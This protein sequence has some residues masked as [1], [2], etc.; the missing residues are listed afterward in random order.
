MYSYM[1]FRT[2]IT[3]TSEMRFKS[4]VSLERG[5][6]DEQ[7]EQDNNIIIQHVFF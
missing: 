7:K 2:R 6:K 4:K 3:E 1:D 5:M